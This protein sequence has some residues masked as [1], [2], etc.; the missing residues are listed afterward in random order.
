MLCYHVGHGVE[1]STAEALRLYELALA[2]GEFKYAPGSLQNL[3]ADIQE[4]SPLLG[5][6]VVLRGLNTAALNGTRGTAVDFVMNQA[7][8]LMRYKVR[9]DGDEGRLVKVRVANVAKA[10]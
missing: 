9:L 5:Q 1:Q 7:E 8:S 10:D 6:K 4:W 3:N 2:R